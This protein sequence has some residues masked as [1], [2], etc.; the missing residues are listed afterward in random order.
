MELLLS[1]FPVFLINWISR[2]TEPPPTRFRF[3]QP[4][5]NVIANRARYSTIMAVR[6]SHVL[7]PLPTQSTLPCNN[8]P[9]FG[10]RAMRNCRNSFTLF[11]LFCH[12]AIPPFRHS[13][14]T[15]FRHYL[16]HSTIPPFYHSAIPLLF[17]N[18]THLLPYGHSAIPPFHHS[19]H[20][21]IRHSTI[22]QLHHS[23]IPVPFCH[24]A[25]L[26]P[27]GNSA[28]P[29][30]HHSAVPSSIPSFRHS[31]IPPFHYH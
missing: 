14:I 8:V 12:S 11:S 7:I 1:L 31:A 6:M 18:S 17:R 19:A 20:S 5:H 26:L 27:F 4:S 22:P 16:R 23:A 13:A 30:F 9:H 24:S 2:P 10:H 29:P 28:I 21:A 25:I 15:P 3:N